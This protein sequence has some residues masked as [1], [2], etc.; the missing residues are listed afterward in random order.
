MKM[1]KMEVCDADC[2]SFAKYIVYL[3]EPDS[4]HIFLCYHHKNLHEKRLRARNAFI[5]ELESYREV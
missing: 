4:G 5:I 1:E 2:I 3:I